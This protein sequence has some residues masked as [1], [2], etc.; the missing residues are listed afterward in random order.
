MKSKKTLFLLMA[1][2]VLFSLPVPAFAAELGN[3]RTTMIYAECSRLPVI[4]VIVPSSMD[5]MINPY[6][7]PIT[8]KNEA[9]GDQ[10][11]SDPVALENKSEVALKVSIS[12]TTVIREGSDMRLASESTVGQELTSKQAFIYFEI[13]PTSD[14]DQVSWAEKYEEE[15]HIM[16]RT[17]TK[18][19][20][21]MVILGAVDQ[22]LSYGA[23]RL[24]GDCVEYPRSA[25]TEADGIDVAIAFTFKATIEAP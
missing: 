15:K 12:M 25:W 3:S 16:V 17:G 22:P 1:V 5:V 21:D 19:R 11:V 24:T 20:K 2:L 4:Q 10:I 23:F 14:P 7:I 8:I 6:Q 18:T 9:I 13:Q